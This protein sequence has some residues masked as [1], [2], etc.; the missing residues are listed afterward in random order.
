MRWKN[1]MLKLQEKMDSYNL[2]GNFDYNLIAALVDAGKDNDK[3]YP[4][5]NSYSF[6]G[7]RKGFLEVR[8]PDNA[9]GV[10]PLKQGLSRI[11]LRRKMLSPV[12]QL[13]RLDIE[14]KDGEYSLTEHALAAICASLP[15][16]RRIVNESISN[17]FVDKL[18][19]EMRNYVFDNRLGAYDSET[20]IYPTALL[21]VVTIYTD[22][23]MSK[24]YIVGVGE[25]AEKWKG[26]DCKVYI[27]SLLSK[28][29]MIEPGWEPV[30]SFDAMRLN[31]L[32]LSF[33][34]KNLS[35]GIDN[36]AD[37]M[38]I[39]DA[40][41]KDTCNGF[42]LDNKTRLLFDLDITYD[43][44]NYRW[45]FQWRF[46]YDIFMIPYGAL[47]TPYQ[48]VCQWMIKLDENE[49]GKV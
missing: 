12:Y 38:H 2:Q 3:V 18:D 10:S 33:N 39:Y 11:E 24:P 41:Q 19:V 34:T 37:F 42:V 31:F 28:E 14:Y 32:S 45:Q 40:Q 47:P 27:D 13:S 25:E 26:F 43:R 8:F 29:F 17:L 23:G 9:S 20:N 30:F 22:L 44:S 35:M 5:E 7:E 15:T 1:A 46:N 21:E 6:N 4:F 48:G 16:F 49:N 36:A